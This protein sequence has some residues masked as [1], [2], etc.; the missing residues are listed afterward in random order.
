MLLLACLLAFA[1]SRSPALPRVPP[2]RVSLSHEILAVHEGTER[3][4]GG[5]VRRH[6]YHECSDYMRCGT[7]TTG[8]ATT[9][10]H[11]SSRST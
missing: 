8:A 11:A 5:D 9:C 1:L 6:T 10:I 7:C 4:V 2:S 3:K